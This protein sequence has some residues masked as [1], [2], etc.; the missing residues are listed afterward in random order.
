[1]R[2]LKI[3]HAID[4]HFSV[5]SVEPRALQKEIA[6]TKSE[7]TLTT[8]RLTV[9]G[10]TCTACS[11]S[12]VDALNSMPGVSR[13]QVSHSLAIAVVTYDSQLVSVGMLIAKVDELGFDAF[14]AQR[15]S[16]WRSS[17]DRAETI[18]RED[19]HHWRTSFLLSL[20]ANVALLIILWRP[21]SSISRTFTSIIKA[22]DF[23][24]SAFSVLFCAAR[25]HKEALSALRGLRGHM[26][27]LSSIGLVA[28]FL[29]PLAQLAL[30]PMPSSELSFNGVAFL[31]TVILGGRLLKALVSRRSLAA[32]TTLISIMST[33]AFL[34]RSHDLESDWFENTCEVPADIL[35]VGDW[36]VVRPGDVVPSDCSIVRGKSDVLETNVTGEIL[37]KYKEPGDLLFAGSTNQSAPIVV[38]V[39]SAGSDTWLEKTLGVVVS[40]DSEK[41]GAQDMTSRLTENFVQIVLGAAVLNLFV[42]RFLAKSTWIESFQSML[43]ILLGACP[44]ALGLSIPSCSMIAICT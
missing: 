44:C 20:G 38:E 40:A 9:T 18:R 7:I 11:S 35:E 41:D 34:M 4:E 42:S 19:I 15:K 22:F 2:M 39:C 10:I 16:T 26:S 33:K 31:T 1:M 23:L 6:V 36:V 32:I 43:A 17:F 14:P 21:M 8:C 3:Y 13:A 29:Q 25:V 27:L 5:F 24:L 30:T 28:G 37:P 12:I